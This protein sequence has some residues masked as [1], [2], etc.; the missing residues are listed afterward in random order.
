MA[1]LVSSLGMSTSVQYPES[2]LFK[3]P[4]MVTHACKP[5]GDV[6]TRESLE[7]MG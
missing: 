5:C 7:L 6:G 4:H 2:M 3:K 1:H